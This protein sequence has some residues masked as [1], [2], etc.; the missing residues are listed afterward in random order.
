MVI[1]FSNEA[2]VRNTV[3]LGITVLFIPP[4]V[5]C[6]KQHFFQLEREFLT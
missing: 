5:L 1:N 2:H 3:F 6:G 4:L